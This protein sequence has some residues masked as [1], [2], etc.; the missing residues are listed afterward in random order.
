MPYL[1]DPYLFTTLSFGSQ[2]TIPR[3]VFCLLFVVFCLPASLFP[4][5]SRR[6][7]LGSRRP[8]QHTRQYATMYPR[9]TPTP[10]CHWVPHRPFHQ[11]IPT[12]PNR[13]NPNTQNP[14][15]QSP[16]HTKRRG[17]PRPH[18]NHPPTRPWKLQR[19]PL[20]RNR[21]SQY[22]NLQRSTHTLPP[23]WGHNTRPRH[24]PTRSTSLT[25]HPSN[26]PTIHKLLP[27]LQHH[28]KTIHIQ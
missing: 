1:C 5:K 15:H 27:Q 18:P 8:P 24:L 2:H 17:K 22:P 14:Q 13:R 3:R 20:P 23:N 25:H 9:P 19:R 12:K 16:H 10:Q 4:S 11:S 21:R 26:M 6:R 7:G 28:N